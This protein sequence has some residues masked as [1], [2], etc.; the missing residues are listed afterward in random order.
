MNSETFKDRVSRTF[1]R[2]VFSNASDN[3][4]PKPWTMAWSGVRT[5]VINQMTPLTATIMEQIDLE[6][7]L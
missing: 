6:L 5:P 7:D 4:S 3:I 1:R 2:L